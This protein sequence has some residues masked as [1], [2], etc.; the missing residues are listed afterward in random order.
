MSKAWVKFLVFLY[1]I[2][3][4]FCLFSL[5]V[6]LISG[7]NYKNNVFAMQNFDM[8]NAEGLIDYQPDTIEFKYLLETS[9]KSGCGWIATY[10]VLKL[11]GE[12]PVIPDIIKS[13]E[14]NGCFAYGYLGTLPWGITDYFSTRGYKVALSLK[15]SEFSG[16]LQDETEIGIAFYLGFK[17][18]HFQAF[19]RVDETRFKFYNYSSVRTMEEYFERHDSNEFLYGLIT[20]KK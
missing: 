9:N 14:I 1:T 19:K 17:G 5:S 3:F 10:N 18:G 20:I 6:F 15:P 16:M 13:L 12:E 11:F 4:I 7:I 8:F 2:I